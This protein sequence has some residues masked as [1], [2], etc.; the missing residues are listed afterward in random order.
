MD[1]ELL[2]YILSFLIA[3]LDSETCDDMRERFPDQ[4]GSMSDDEVEQELSRMLN[5]WP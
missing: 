4:F 3:N 2:D 5:T 1:K